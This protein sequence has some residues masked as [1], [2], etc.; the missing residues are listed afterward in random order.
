MKNERQFNWDS[1][2]QPG[3]VVLGI[4]GAVIPLHLSIREDVRAM[5]SKIEAHRVETNTIL[6]AMR[7]DM[8]DF[9]GRLCAIEERNKK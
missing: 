2:I 5:D 1:L 9:H 7:D 6:Q 8:R 3:V 4:L